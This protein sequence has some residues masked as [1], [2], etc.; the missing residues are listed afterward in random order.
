MS[1]MR[2]LRMRKPKGNTKNSKTGS[3]TLDLS[4]INEETISK[5]KASMK[6]SAIPDMGE[7][8]EIV[9]ELLAYIETPQMRELEESNFQEFETAIY[10]MY[11]SKLPMKVISLMIEGDRY[12]HLDRLI[13]TFETLGKIK[14]G[15]LDM[16]TEFQKFNDKLNDEFVYEP[17]GGKENFEK[18]FIKP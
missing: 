2:K 18:Q 6:P 7:M 11:N 16:Q 17:A 14:A 13:T 12:D 10:G 15:E 5:F 1:Q 4:S 9:N 8:L 3:E